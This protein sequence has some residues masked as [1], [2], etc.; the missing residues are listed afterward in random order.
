MGLRDSH[1]E[2]VTLAPTSREGSAD[3][4]APPCC[5]GDGWAH[6]RAFSGKRQE[7]SAH[8]RSHTTALHRAVLELPQDGR[9]PRRCPSPAPT[10]RPPANLFL[11]LS[12]LGLSLECVPFI[13]SEDALPPA[14]GL[15]VGDASSQSYCLRPK[16][17]GGSS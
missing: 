10:P 16:R 15:G 14:Q 11:C 12:S 5:C 13:S 8:H 17:E 7:P 1:G 4:Q 2:E 3:G 9:E 6:L